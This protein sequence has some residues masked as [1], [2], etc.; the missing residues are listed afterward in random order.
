MSTIEKKKQIRFVTNADNFSKIPGSPIAYKATSKIISIY[1][2]SKTLEDVCSPRQGLA[3]ADTER[4]LKLWYEVNSKTI[5]FDARDALIAKHSNRKWFPINKGGSFRKWY[6]NNEYIVN[7]K[8]DGSE[9][10]AFPKAVIRNPSYY[11]FEGGTWTAIS[12]GSFSIRYFPNGYLFSNAGMAIFESHDKLLYIIGFL[13]S[14]LSQLFLHTLNESLNYN[15]GDIA[16][17]PI[18]ETKEHNTLVKSKV[19]ELIDVSKSDWDSFETSW[20]FKKHPL[21]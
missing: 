19:E 11:F 21:I 9:M 20:D 5:L 8:N 6:G 1:K 13:N 18:V 10:R 15:Q 16:R 14:H 3:S 2:K 4:F 12:S 17:L 7:W